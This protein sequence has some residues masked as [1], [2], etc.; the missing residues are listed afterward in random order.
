MGSSGGNLIDDPISVKQ[1]V[2]V[3][4]FNVYAVYVYCVWLLQNKSA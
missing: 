3:L 1:A 4:V 2:E